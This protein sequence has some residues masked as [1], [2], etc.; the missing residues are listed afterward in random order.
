MRESIDVVLVAYNRFDLTESCLRHL[1]AQGIEHHVIVVDNGSTDDTRARLRAEW[2]QVQLECID[3]NRGFAEA[4]NRGVA[5][6]GA[7]VV[8]LI[9][10]DVDCSPD[11]LERVVA[12]LADPSVGS[13]A[14]LMLQPGSETIDSVGLAVDAVLAGFPRLRGLP[15]ACARRVSPV[16]VGPAGTAGAYR[17]SAWE[18]VGGLDETIFAYMEDLDLA[19][20]L[21]MAGWRSVAAPDAK[22]VHLGS[23]THGLRSSWQR[24][25]AGFGRGYVLRR[26][27]L[28][29][30]RSAPRAALTEAIVVA[31]DL[32]LSHDLAA[33][34]GRLAGWSAGRQAPRLPRPPAE[35]V[36]ANIGFLGSLALRRS[37]YGQRAA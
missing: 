7:E 22:G 35:C 1:R 37:T 18:Q 31:G 13:V 27:G 6:G 2:P 5:A 16:I 17:R 25:Q 34:R 21:R 10:N 33:L 14:S 20:R 24:L 11:F 4:C 19:L 26:Y 32:F 23:A 8:V 3:D 36:D 30:G 28:M 29:R 9:N 15:V 12:P